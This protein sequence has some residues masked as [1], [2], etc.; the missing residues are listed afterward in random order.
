MQNDDL[1]HK[2]IAALNQKAKGHYRQHQVI[3]GVFTRI[4]QKEHERFNRWGIAGFALAAAITG[5]VVVPNGF[6]NDAQNPSQI[7]VNTPKLTP[8]LADDLEMLLVLGEDI[9]HGS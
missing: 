8:Q 6:F 3:N 1:Q 7:V 9:T 4:A 2:I 5:I